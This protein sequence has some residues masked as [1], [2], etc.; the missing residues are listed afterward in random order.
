MKY[1][2]EIVYFKILFYRWNDEVME[3]MSNKP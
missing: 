1:L 2:D 3:K